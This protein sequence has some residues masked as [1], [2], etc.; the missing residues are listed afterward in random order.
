MCT[1]SI[2]MPAYNASRYIS[3]AINSVINQTFQD[4]EI[5]VVDDCSTDD[6]SAVVSQISTVDKRVR[7]VQ[8]Q[9]NVGAGN[10]RNIAI[11][12][13][14]GRFIAFLDCDDLWLPSKLEIQLKFMIEN[15]HPFVYAAYSKIDFNGG[16]LGT[17]GVPERLNYTDLLKACYIGC[18]TV[19]YDT[20][21][22]G[23]VY[24]PVIRKRQ[25]Y[26]LWLK[27][28]KEIEFA[29]GQNVVLAKYRVHVG[30]ISSNKLDAA[31][32]TWSVYRDIENL[33]LRKSV[34]FFSNYAVRGVLRKYF[35]RLAKLVGFLN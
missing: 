2:V 17:M 30:S 6:T 16:V 25:D 22:F 7:L 3:E 28:L 5:I 27:L 9:E 34:F 12:A 8:L 18:L 31:R 14:K 15:K 29:F 13:A 23:K 32:Y 35:P 4:W 11:S 19:I 1:V 33:G 20:E 24:M 10:A 26:A 21:Y